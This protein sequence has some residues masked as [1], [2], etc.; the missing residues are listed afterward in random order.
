MFYKNDPFLEKYIFP[1]GGT[2]KMKQNLKIFR[3]YFKEVDRNDFPENSYPKTLNCWYGDFCKNEDGIRRLLTEKSR[4]KDVDFSIRVF[5]HYLMLAY[6]GLSDGFG[7]VANV[8]V[9]NKK[10]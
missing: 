6:C 9:K 10:A 5:K 7:L 4:V 2:P 3:K 1:G 8:L